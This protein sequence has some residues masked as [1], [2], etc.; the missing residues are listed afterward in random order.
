MAESQST[1]R[2]DMRSESDRRAG[3]YRSHRRRTVSVML[4]A[5]GIMLGLAMW[6]IA[7]RNRNNRR[8]F[9]RRRRY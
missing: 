6:G 7:R 8:R 4:V 3:E 5:G 1:M 2:S 9:S